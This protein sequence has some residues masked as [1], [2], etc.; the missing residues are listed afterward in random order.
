MR[1]M[2]KQQGDDAAAPK[3]AAG[4]G[5]AAD[6]A[7]P[8][9]AADEGA[10][11]APAAVPADAKDAVTRPEQQSQQDDKDE[12][13][14][15][16]AR[17][18]WF[19]NFAD[20]VSEAKETGKI[21][22]QAVDSFDQHGK[23]AL[24]SI[25]EIGR[26]RTVAQ[27]A[28]KDYLGMLDKAS[29]IRSDM[30]QAFLKKLG[31]EE[32]QTRA[33]TK[34][35][36]GTG[37]LSGDD[38]LVLPGVQKETDSAVAKRLA[39]LDRELER[40]SV[41]SPEERVTTFKTLA[42]GPKDAEKAR[43]ST[44]ELEKQLKDLVTDGT[45]S[46]AEQVEQLYPKKVSAA[47]PASFVQLAS[48]SSTSVTA[49]GAAPSAGKMLNKVEN[50]HGSAA[51]AT[52]T[53]KPNSF[54]QQQVPAVAAA[55]E[56]S[57][58]A[59]KT[60]SPSTGGTDPESPVYV[61]V[62]RAAQ[63]L[64]TGFAALDEEI[65]TTAERLRKL[66]KLC[67]LLQYD[68]S[69]SGSA[70]AAECSEKW[71]ETD[72]AFDMLKEKRKTCGERE[73]SWK[74][75]VLTTIANASNDEN[76][77]KVQPRD[78]VYKTIYKSITQLYQGLTS[79]QMQG[80]GSVDEDAKPNAPQLYDTATKSTSRQLARECFQ[81]GMKVGLAF[82]DLVRGANAQPGSFDRAKAR[83]LDTRDEVEQRIVFLQMEGQDSSLWAPVN[84]N[85]DALIDQTE[86]VGAEKGK[87]D[88]SWFR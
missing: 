79:E 44:E 26:R 54:I 63:A 61:A 67:P 22:D 23:D 35:F 27:E 7:T 33:E 32:K 73:A 52:A 18:A 24:V 2:Q 45:K 71:H 41:M 8:A 15:H 86:G 64:E 69:E 3:E 60:K 57:A 51:D 53:S 37:F 21:V 72:H 82:L 11:A 56:G 47:N 1:Q 34:A 17:D 78:A 46:T 16:A 80:V 83:M 28:A 70:A 84:K 4:G 87:S 40:F 62:A 85:L 38:A 77:D 66:Q 81:T 13:D 59:A 55:T 30:R 75:Q 58:S 76:S 88:S 10:A 39:S 48:D 12:A 5:D 20:V 25:H 14:E 29:T 36:P 43:K 74:K 19:A 68:R 65:A 31:Q 42:A 50:K 49:T 6:A 9:A